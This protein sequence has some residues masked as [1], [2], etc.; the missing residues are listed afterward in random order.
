MQFLRAHPYLDALVTAAALIIVGVLIVRTQLAA[1]TQSA[2]DLT[3]GSDGG[4]F[5]NTVSDG[6]TALPTTQAGPT[7][8]AKDIGYIP[9]QT[10]NEIGTGPQDTSADFDFA[11]FAAALS[12]PKSSKPVDT[13][14]PS[15]AYDFIPTGLIATTTLTK[16]RTS[17]QNQLYM[18]GNDVGDTITSFEN[19]HPDQPAILKNQMEQRD[20]PAAAA[21]LR[22]LGDDLAH[23]GETL[24]A[25]DLVPT[26]ARS[27][28]AGLAAAYTDI[29]TKLAAVADAKGDDAT[30]A[31]IVSYDKAADDFAKKYVALA[32]VFQAY[33]ITFSPGDGGSLFVFPSGGL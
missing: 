30:Y 8:Q 20:D 31:A 14:E 17:L 21:A 7:M 29:G 2:S 26:Q 23:V 16:A 4:V 3:W 18:Y 13:G 12:R 25:M 24:A 27:A 9:L 28:H 22:G 1:P 32:Q 33:D 15:S 19:S 10:Q 11:T 6:H 5:V